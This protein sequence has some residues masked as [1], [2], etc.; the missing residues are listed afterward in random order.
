MSSSLY[1]LALAC[2]VI[3]LWSLNNSV[4]LFHFTNLAALLYLSFLIPQAIAVDSA[5]VGRLYGASN[6]WWY[7]LLCLLMI[8]VGFSATMRQSQRKAR[9]RP[10]KV[11]DEKRLQFGAVALL[12]VGAASSLRVSQMATSATLGNQW[13]GEI[14]LWYLLMQCVFFSL[15]ISLL[16]FFKTKKKLYAV[17]GCASLA[18]VL[19]M[20]GLNAKRHMIAEVALIF[21]GIWVFIY[22]RPIP[23]PLMLIGILIGTVLIH[24]VGSVRQYIKEGR[25]NTFEAIVRGVPFERFEYFNLD[26]RNAPEVTQ[27]VV[28]I[29]A[30]NFSNAIEGPAELWN[31]V[32]HQYVPGFIVGPAVKESMK[33]QSNR[34]IVDLGL[35]SF[36]RPGATRTG[37]SDTYRSFWIFGSVMFLGIGAIMGIL[38]GYASQGR[39]WAQFYYIILLNDALISI[40]ESV[41]RFY[42]TIPFVVALTLPFVMPRSRAIAHLPRR[43]GGAPTSLSVASR[44]LPPLR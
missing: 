40:T 20:V 19:M 34:A 24:Q 15:A 5:S 2:V 44:T 26:A 12:L 3:A 38:Y 23:R 17:V 25:G 9:S 31:T 27:A 41:S 14:T 11:V 39:V 6:V 7:M 43:A 1:F 28:D 33:M 13:T 10:P 30:A 42:A 21:A 4:K 37:F 8:A 22:R 18:L 16:R 35:D 32:V 29:H 36:T